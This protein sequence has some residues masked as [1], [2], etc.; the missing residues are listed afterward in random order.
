MPSP[1]LLWQ[2]GAATHAIGVALASIQTIFPN[3]ATGN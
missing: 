1:V 3:M 2:M